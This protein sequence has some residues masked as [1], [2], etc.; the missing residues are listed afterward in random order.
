[1]TNAEN[2]E[3]G[4]VFEGIKTKKAREQIIRLL[5]CCK[6][7]RNTAYPLKNSSVTEL[8][9]VDLR[10]QKQKDYIY[11]TGTLLL[12]DNKEEETR[13]FEAYIT[14]KENENHILLDITRIELKETPKMIRTTDIIRE[15]EDLIISQTTY[16]GI[17]Y[18]QEKSYQEELDKNI[19]FNI[20]KL[21]VS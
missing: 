18:L 20:K 14:N 6:E 16:C 2:Y 10:A 4:Y 21:S 8:S 11:V 15:E 12:K 13:T 3:E 19:L 17:G 5:K 7:I 1:M 9:I